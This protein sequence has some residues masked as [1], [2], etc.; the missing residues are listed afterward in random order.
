MHEKEIEVNRYSQSYFNTYN[1]LEHIKTSS[2]MYSGFDVSMNN[3]EIPNEFSVFYEYM[4]SIDNKYNQFIANWYKDKNDGIFK[5]SDCQ[6]G[7]IDNYKIT[8]LSLYPKNDCNDFRIF[9]LKSKLNEKEYNIRLDHRLIISM[10]GTTQNEFI[11]GINKS[12][13][14]VL[15]S[16]FTMSTNN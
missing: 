13:T 15:P 5:H 10:C 6:K 16:L 8:I 2:Y 4:K 1:D 9:S 12:L 7:M 14:E 11:H 3:L